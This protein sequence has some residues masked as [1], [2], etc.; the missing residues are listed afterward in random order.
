MATVPEYILPEDFDPDQLDW[1]N[2][3]LTKLDT[4]DK[5]KLLEL[6]NKMDNMIT[7]TRINSVYPEYGQFSRHL[8]PKQL[9]FFKDSREYLIKVLMGGNRTG[10]TLTGSYEVACQATGVY[11]PWWE[12]RICKKPQDIWVAGDTG[13]TVRDILQTE[14]LG[15]PG[16]EGTGMIP[17]NAIV[18]LTKSSGTAN[19]I[20][21]VTVKHASGGHSQIQFK[22]FEQGRKTFQGKSIDLI[23]LDEE[24]PQEIY[25]ECL[26]RTM[27]NYGRVMLTFTPL[28]GTTPLIQ[29]LIKQSQ[30]KEP[31]VSI[32]YVT[33][34]D[35][36]HLS[37]EVKKQFW[38][39]LPPF[40]REARSKGIPTL[41]AGA[42]YPIAEDR[43]TVD[44]FGIPDH[45]PRVFGLD[46]GWRNTAAV[47][48]AKNPDTGVMYAYSDYKVGEK[49]PVEH[50]RSLKTRGSWIPCI[51]DH[52]A[53]GSAQTNGESVAT[54]YKEEGL[55]IHNANK[56][57]E[58]GL[59]R[60]FR[61]FQDGTLKIFKTCSY[62]LD[63]FKLYHRDEKGNIVKEHDHCLDAM[64][65]ALMGFEDHAKA[66]ADIKKANPINPYN[67]NITKR[68][69]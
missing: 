8:Y 55:T 31:N 49:D 34:D 39:T 28:M 52:A 40:Q 64:R 14:L 35:V 41:G 1:A 67:I 58:A 50:T 13:K 59:Q 65:Y 10:K 38:E 63:E 26:A 43:I 69:I 36:P 9:K 32:T 37:E 29:D 3:D 4:M 56:A 60:C 7:Y 46:P 33:W 57:V 30:L 12:G 18:K 20:D 48:I 47:W 45:W 27:T 5:R 42:V 25:E 54:L 23:W 16:E 68:V 66:E 2:I 44:A 53:N 61:A 11:P 62:L 6:M 17:K 19:S 51:I 15:K 22:T 24:A 21:T